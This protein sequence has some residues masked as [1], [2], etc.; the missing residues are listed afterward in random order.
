MSNALPIFV[1]EDRN[2]TIFVVCRKG[3]D[4]RKAALELVKIGYKNVHNLCGGL[5]AW[6]RMD[7]SFPVY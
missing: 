6:S 3:N 4:S 7:P 1:P 2:A 5:E